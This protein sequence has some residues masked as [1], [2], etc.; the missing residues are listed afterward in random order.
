MAVFDLYAACNEMAR[1]LAAVTPPSGDLMRKAYGQQP[2]GAPSLPAAIVVPEHGTLILQPSTYFGDHKVD[3]WFL[4]E[5]ASIDFKRI[6][7]RRQKWLPILYHAFDG[8]MALTLA[9]VVLKVFPIGWEFTEIVYGG[10]S[11]DGIILHYELDTSETV[12]LV[13]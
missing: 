4:I 9:P 2:N 12:S 10:V 5:K 6:E 13:P 3:V 7:A 8:E 11:Y 1:L